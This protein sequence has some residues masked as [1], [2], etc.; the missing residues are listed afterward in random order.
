MKRNQIK[1]IRNEKK[2]KLKK[3]K[4]KEKIMQKQENAEKEI[5]FSSL[6]ENDAICQCV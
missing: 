4:E 5:S 3:R 6:V 2:K 1:N